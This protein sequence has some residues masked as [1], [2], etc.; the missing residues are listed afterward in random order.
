MDGWASSSGCPA[1]SPGA[2]GVEFFVD[3]KTKRTGSRDEAQPVRKSWVVDESVG[4][5]DDK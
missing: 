4:D 2:L 5:H 3:R 1:R